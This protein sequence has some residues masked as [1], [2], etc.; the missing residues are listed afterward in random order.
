MT[1]PL[2]L[3]REKFRDRQTRLELAAAT[4]KGKPINFSRLW[5]CIVIKKAARAAPAACERPRF[6]AIVPRRTGSLGAGRSSWVSAA[7]GT[8]Y[9][10]LS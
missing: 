5:D 3:R 8:G 1:M 10:S 2:E 7:C 6:A 9:S 4:T